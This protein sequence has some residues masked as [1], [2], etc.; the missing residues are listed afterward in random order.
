MTLLSQITKSLN[1]GMKRFGYNRIPGS[2][3]YRIC[4]NEATD[5]FVGFGTSTFGIEGMLVSP[6]VYVVNK[7]SNEMLKTA[8]ERTGAPDWYIF[9]SEVSI[10]PRIQEALWRLLPSEELTKPFIHQNAPHPSL[11][12]EWHF[13]NQAVFD[14]KIFDETMAHMLEMVERYGGPF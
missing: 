2:R 13:S 1:G 11:D 12:H 5:G 3:T 10:I 14:P 4:V 6:L 9:P 8:I 7:P